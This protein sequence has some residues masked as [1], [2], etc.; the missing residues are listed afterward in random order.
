MPPGTRF[1][2]PLALLVCAAVSLSAYAADPPRSDKF[3]GPPR[4]PPSR[5][6]DFLHLRLDCS[7][8]WAEKCIEGT[9][10]HRVRS[11]RKGARF[12]STTSVA[13]RATEGRFETCCLSSPFHCDAKAK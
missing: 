2:S 10:S 11:Y 4:E 5:D 13:S 3:S 7:F 6:F 8:D 1:S 9:V 12:W